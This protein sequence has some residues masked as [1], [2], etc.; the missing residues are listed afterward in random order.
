VGVFAATMFPNLVVASEAS[1]GQSIT[2]TAAS[3]ELTLMWMT[4]I[5]CVGLPLVLIY[6]FILYRTFKGRVKVKDLIY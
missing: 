3:G 5:T 2:V 6:H 4:G 1:I